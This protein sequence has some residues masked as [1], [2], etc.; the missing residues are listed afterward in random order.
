M[1]VLEE[2]QPPVSLVWGSG[3]TTQLRACICI[4]TSKFNILNLGTWVGGW[5]S[6]AGLMHTPLASPHLIHWQ[7]TVYPWCNQQCHKLHLWANE[8][9]WRT[10]IINF[11][12]P[13][14]VNMCCGII[15]EHL[16]GPY[17]LQENLTGDNYANFMHNELSTLL[18]DVLL[19]T[20]RHH[21]QHVVHPH[22]STWCSIYMSSYLIGGFP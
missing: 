14:A 9:P 10:V 17:I 4:V 12:Y 1:L 6:V 15:G 8:N 7:R 18:E 22:I 16:V 11:Q 3:N 5:N 19:Q 2:F 20:D 21:F 13:F